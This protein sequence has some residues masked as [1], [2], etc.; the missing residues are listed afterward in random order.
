MAIDTEMPD[1]Q[2]RP[3]WSAAFGAPGAV[4][5][6][7]RGIGTAAGTDQKVPAPPPSIAIL[8]L[9][10]KPETPGAAGGSGERH[11]RV[12]WIGWIRRRVFHAEPGRKFT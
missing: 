8:A 2:T 9:P 1:R 10:A 6:G 12:R 11:R 4:E 3:T 7:E 5:P